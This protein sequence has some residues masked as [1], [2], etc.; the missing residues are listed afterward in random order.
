[1]RDC[2]VL[3][4]LEHLFMRGFVGVERTVEING[5]VYKCLRYGWEIVSE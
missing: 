4:K 5:V 1:V 2:D 3:E